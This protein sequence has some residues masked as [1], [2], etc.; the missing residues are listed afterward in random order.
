MEILSIKGIVDAELTEQR[1]ALFA[2]H[3]RASPT[4]LLCAVSGGW[5]KQ[6]NRFEARQVAAPG[7]VLSFEASNAVAGFSF[8]KALLVLQ[9]IAGCEAPQQESEV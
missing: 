9:D 6:A 3:V 4:Q 7:S 2:G 1:E 8:D 5:S